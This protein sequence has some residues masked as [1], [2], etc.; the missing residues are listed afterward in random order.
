MKKVSNMHRY[1]IEILYSPEDGGSW[2]RMA[3]A[4]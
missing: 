4:S 3:Q 1:A 2:T